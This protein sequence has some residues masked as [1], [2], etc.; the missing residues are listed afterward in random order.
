MTHSQGLHCLCGLT[1]KKTTNTD[2]HSVLVSHSVQLHPHRSLPASFY[3][4]LPPFLSCLSVMQSN[5]HWI[6]KLY[7]ATVFN[8]SV[9]QASSYLSASHILPQLSLPSLCLLLSL[10]ANPPSS[11]LHLFQPSLCVFL[12]PCSLSVSL[13]LTIYPSILC[14]LSWCKSWWQQA[15]RVA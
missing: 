5:H 9:L 12:S 15:K 2:T 10:L 14:H 8:F 4:P 6:Q 7:T 11:S 13:S 3:S 1:W